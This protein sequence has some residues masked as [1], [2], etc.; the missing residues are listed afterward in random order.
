MA[1]EQRRIA[2]GLVVLAVIAAACR[3]DGPVASSTSVPGGTP[4]TISQTADRY[5]VELE[6]AYDDW[7]RVP[8]SGVQPRELTTSYTIGPVTLAVGEARGVDVTGDID[9]VV[10]CYEGLP[11]FDAQLV[12]T[13]ADEEPVDFALS[14][15][16]LSSIREPDPEAQWLAG[17]AVG[18]LELGG[19]IA[20]VH[21]LAAGHD[22][23]GPLPDCDGTVRSMLVFEAGAGA[24][25]QPSVTVGDGDEVLS[26]AEVL[27]IESPPSYVDG[28]GPASGWVLH[29]LDEEGPAAIV[30]E[31]ESV[32]ELGGYRL[33]VT[34]AMAPAP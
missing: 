19:G 8:G 28:E 3:A 26:R 33:R 14:A 10:R 22:L 5:T 31:R 24:L 29:V 18:V 6:V 9:W 13:E 16:S 23:R 25:T 4:S 34:G 7:F 15:P 32:D 1:M 12:W 2:V 11:A 21:R 30:F 17:P 27:A 20:L